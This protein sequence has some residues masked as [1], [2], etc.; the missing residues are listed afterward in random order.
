[1]TYTDNWKNEIKSINKL[2]C[3]RL[4]DREYSPA[5]YLVSIKNPKQRR[6]LTMYRL[7]D[8]QLQVE[9][10]RHQKEWKPR[11]LRVCKHCSSGEIETEAHF[12]LSCPLYQTEREAFLQQITAA[13][14][15]YQG[16]KCDELLKVCLGEDPQFIK[17]AAQYVTVC[18]D[19]MVTRMLIRTIIAIV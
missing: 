19:A 6:T 18:H 13:D 15:S 16:T 3:Y 5:Q 10:G 9:K 8:H 1:M 12:L 7:T 17:L 4:L 2:E 11:E 14:P